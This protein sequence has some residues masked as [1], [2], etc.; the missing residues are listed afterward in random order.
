MAR[1]GEQAGAGW[2]SVKRRPWRARA[3][4]CGVSISPPKAPRSEKPRSSATMTRKLGRLLIGRLFAHEGAQL[5]AVRVA[6]IGGVKDRVHP[7]AHAR[8]TFV[9]P[10]VS[11]GRD[12]EGVDGG[13]I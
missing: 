1:V 13:P 7:L 6:H 9:G 3:S 2:K 5:V 8:R 10:A 11:Q 12:V 4:R